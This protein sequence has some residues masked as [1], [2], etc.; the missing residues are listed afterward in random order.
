MS[1]QSLPLPTGRERRRTAVASLLDPAILLPALPEMVRKLDP[2]TD[3]QE[4]G[5][6]RGRGR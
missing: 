1:T 2:R 4:P 3:D 6:V 5:H